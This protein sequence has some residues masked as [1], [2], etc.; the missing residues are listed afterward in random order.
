MG[1]LKVGVWVQAGVEEAFAEG[2][3][4]RCDAGSCVVGYTPVAE[5]RLRGSLLGESK[6]LHRQEARPTKKEVNGELWLSCQGNFAKVITTP[7]ASISWRTM[8]GAGCIKCPHT[9]ATD[10]PTCTQHL[11]VPPLLTCQKWTPLHSTVSVP[12]ETST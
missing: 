7:K 5:R 8:A 9:H 1:T 4:S 6:P 2:T 12:P 10:I 11:H 3:T